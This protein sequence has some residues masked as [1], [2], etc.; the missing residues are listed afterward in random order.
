MDNPFPNMS[1]EEQLQDLLRSS[2]EFTLLVDSRNILTVPLKRATDTDEEMQGNAPTPQCFRKDGTGW[3]L[4]SVSISGSGGLSMG[5]GA[6]SDVSG[7][8]YLR[9]PFTIAF[10]SGPVN[11]VGDDSIGADAMLWKMRFA[12]KRALNKK[13]VWLPGGEGS[14][15]RVMND[16]SPPVSVPEFPGAGKVMLERVRSIGVMERS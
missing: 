16:I 13:I 7:S 15:L 3:L 14:W 11:V 1:V 9:A 6:I 4:P 5:G 2:P 10:Y 8:R 12:M